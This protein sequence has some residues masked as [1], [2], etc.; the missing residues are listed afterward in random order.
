MSIQEKKFKKYFKE[1]QF[2]KSELEFVLEIL[3]AAHWDFEE[4]YRQYCK[5]KEINLE[6]LNDKNREKIDKIIPSPTKQLYDESDVIV[7][8]RIEFKDN[9]DMKCF[10]K[11]YREAVKKC[12]PDAGGDELE[13]KKLSQAHE[14]KDWEQLLGVCE[15]YNIKLEDYASLNK[16]LIKEIETVKSKIKKEKSTYSWLLYECGGSKT[17]KD[18]VVK[19]FLKHL[20][21]YGDYK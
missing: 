17:C 1:L 18:N 8:K 6:S 15:K 13:F 3:K 12:H 9:T 16:I 21:D 20:F 14:E 2:N 4:Y 11:L 5:D 19:K 10:K 7:T